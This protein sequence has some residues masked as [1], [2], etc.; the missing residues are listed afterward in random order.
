MTIDP[1]ASK[2][3]A[4]MGVVLRLAGIYNILWGAWV[5][6]APG[7]LFDWF[8]IDRPQPI[9]IWQCVGMIVG[10]Y[11]VGYWVAASN[12][13]RHWPIV[14]VGM[15]GKIFGPIGFA[16]AVFDG[17]FPPAFGLTILT[18]DLIWWVP[19]SL[20][21]VH[22]YR[23][24]GRRVAQSIERTSVDVREALA[25]I[26]TSA[27]D[28]LLEL[29]HRGPVLLVFL[30]HLGCTFCREALADVARDR[31]SIEANG[32]TIALVHMSDDAVA[33]KFSAK[34]GL[35]DV[36][37][38]SDPEKRLYNAFDLARGSLGQLFG[39]EVWLRGFDAGVLHKHAVGKLEGDGF[40]MPGAFLVHDGAIVAAFRHESAGDRPDYCAIADHDPSEAPVPEPA[41]V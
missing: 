21:L 20:I 39:L 32:A 13:A 28:P 38:I 27:G 19:F 8:G 10:V 25:G 31:A 17:I 34:Y 5:V 11:G 4:W 1:F 2:S 26:R 22:A 23:E 16:Q 33:E 9:E 7:M 3:P 40:Q 14:L 36:A 18:N 29:S 6:F 35:G 24:R 41:L 37:R 30:R 15:L 12:P